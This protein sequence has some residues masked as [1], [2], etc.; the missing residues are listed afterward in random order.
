MA[1]VN[2]AGYDPWAPKALAANP[3]SG[4]AVLDVGALLGL[5]DGDNPHQ[6]YSPASVRRVI[7]AIVADYG[8]LDPRDAPYFA[9][10]QRAFEAQGLAEYDRLR[11]DIR[12]RYAGVPVGASESIFVPLAADLGLSLITPASFTKAIAEGTD[13]SA[14]DKV[15]VDRQI[16]S[17]QIRVWVYNSQNSTPDVKRLTDEARSRA[18]PITTITETLTPASASFEAW[19]AAELRS[20]ES[21]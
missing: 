14:T 15:T 10:R 13:V 12:R 18:I 8:R 19:Q 5:H 3:V 6:W 7:Q 4:R 9:A 11:T 1:I 20:L 2:G 17:H 16:L 21:A